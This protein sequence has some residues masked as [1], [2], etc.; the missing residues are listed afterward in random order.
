MKEKDATR[1][2]RR[3]A[4]SG[5]I[6]RRAWERL[7]SAGAAGDPAAR[8]SVI[9]IA[10]SAGE[11]NHPRRAE[12]RA[13]VASWWAVTRD[14][15]LRDAVRRHLLL[16]DAGWERWVTAA[17]HGQLLVLWRPGAAAAVPRLLSDQDPAVSAGAEAAFAL[18]SEPI[19]GE[20]WR[21]LSDGSPG[22]DV[23]T[24]NPNELSPATREI[25]ISRW[26]RADGEWLLAAAMGAQT[27]EH[28]RPALLAACRERRLAPADP[29]ERGL[30]YLLTG[31]LDRC[32]AADPGLG[33][34]VRTLYA[35]MSQ[36]HREQLRRELVDSGQLD[37]VRLL[38]ADSDVGDAGRDAVLRQLAARADWPELWRMTLSLPAIEAVAAIRMFDRWRPP[39]EHDQVLFDRFARADGAR[40]AQARSRRAGHRTGWGMN[41]PAIRIPARRGW[42]RPPRR[43]SH[44]AP[45][46]LARTTSSGSKT[47]CRSP[48]VPAMSSSSRS[49]A[50]K[51]KASCGSRTELSGMSEAS[52]NSMS[53]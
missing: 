51:P 3:S 34:A 39:D 37:L 11:V 15:D 7:E 29:D 22:L 4:R 20:L 45:T 35:T 13:A 50:A 23:L 12:A 48:T 30:F 53:S 44:P 27:P 19:L 21:A 32:L 33:E 25:A 9:R 18:A 16:A 36:Q 43:R 47:R 52:P 41:H 42:R 17:M 46:E 2:T 26:A 10:T 49:T 5:R 1:L 31:Q 28:L 38:A 14:A 8:T 6:A 40:L 24:H